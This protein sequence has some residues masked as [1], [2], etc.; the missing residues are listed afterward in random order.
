[1]HMRK[2]FLLFI[3][4]VFFAVQAMAQRTV[5]GKVTDDKGNPLANVSILVKGTTNGTV[6][7][8]DGTYT[9]AVPANAKTLVISSINM[10]EAQID[11]GNKY[12][13]N[14]SLQTSEKSLQEVVV[15][16][17]GIT[18]DKRSLGYASQNLKGDEL[19]N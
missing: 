19:A 18:R 3:G 8:L 12:V 6:T 16:A 13:V 4:V 17:L 1:M 11:I 15:T 7:K 10:K 9:L 5:T 2:S 14:V